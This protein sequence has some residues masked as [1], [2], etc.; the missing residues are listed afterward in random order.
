MAGFL[1]LKGNKKQENR[2]VVHFTIIEIMING[3]IFL[4]LNSNFEDIKILKK[5]VQVCFYRECLTYYP[6]GFFE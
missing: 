1:K 5:S 3:L 4:A 2:N 6:I